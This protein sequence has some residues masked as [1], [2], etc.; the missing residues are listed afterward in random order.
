MTE[1]RP[2]NKPREV[3]IATSVEVCSRSFTTLLSIL[4]DPASGASEN[5][6]PSALR[7]EFGRFKIWVGNIAE[8]RR[9]RRSLEYRLRDASHIKERTLEILEGLNNA[10]QDS[11]WA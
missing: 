1:V 7:D 8:H 5:L 4:E 6:S 2:S 9:D 11:E 10:L 3:D